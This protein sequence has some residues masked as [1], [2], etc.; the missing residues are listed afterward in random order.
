MI[1]KLTDSALAQGK[2]DEN[3]VIEVFYRS[4]CNENI[5]LSE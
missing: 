5:G 1:L 2:F 4:R 3:F